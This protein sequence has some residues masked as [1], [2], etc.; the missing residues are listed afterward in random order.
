MGAPVVH[1]EIM[2]GK[3]SELETFYRELFGWKINS[4]NPM[5]YGVVETGGGLGGINGGVGPSMT[6]ANAFPYMR[7]SKTC[8]L[9][10]IGQSVLE[11][12]RSF[13]RP[14]CREAPSW[15]CLPIPPV[16]SQGFFWESGSPNPNANACKW[17]CCDFQSTTVGGPYHER[18]RRSRGSAQTL[19]RWSDRRQDA[20]L[21]GGPPAAVLLC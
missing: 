6:G 20:S 1:F 12:K 2:G 9:R 3:G 11:A 10:L 19:V 16:I 18:S 13:R 21:T 4:N 17:G 15:P 14:K 5:K 8:R 7:G